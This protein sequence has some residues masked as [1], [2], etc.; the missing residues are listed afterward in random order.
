MKNEG[1]LTMI[2]IAMPPGQYGAM[3]IAQWSASVA[4]CQVTQCHHWASARAVSPRRP[5]W[6]MILNETQKH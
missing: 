4:S 1:K 6:S 3:H 5:P 2:S